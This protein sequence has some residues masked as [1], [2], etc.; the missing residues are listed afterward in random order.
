[1]SLLLL[2]TR[3][4][5]LVRAGLEAYYDFE[6][7]NLARHSEEFDNT[8]W[9]VGPV[10]P[11]LEVSPRG[12]V[13]ADSLADQSATVTQEYTQAVA[14]ISSTDSYTFSLYVKKDND[15][16]R[17]PEFRIQPA[18]GVTEPLTAGQ[19]NTKTGALTVRTGGGALSVSDEGA[20]W[21][22]A[23]IETDND[24]GNTEVM[25]HRPSL[26]HNIWWRRGCDANRIDCCLGRPT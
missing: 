8:V 3:N 25:L 4:S 12:D 23:V 11:N 24:S 9:G 26:L 22:V 14:V 17:F 19:I 7:N 20:F 5:G 10:T 1:M 15:E 6:K 2:H 21:R 18:G 13:T 16:S